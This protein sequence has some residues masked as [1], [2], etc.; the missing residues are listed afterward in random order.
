MGTSPDAN[1]NMYRVNN[2]VITPR[3]YEPPENIFLFFSPVISA[4][5]SNVLVRHF[6]PKN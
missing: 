4:L 5:K 1:Q 2:E 3:V 6:Q